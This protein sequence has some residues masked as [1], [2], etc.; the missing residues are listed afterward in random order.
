MLPIHQGTGQRLRSLRK[1]GLPGYPWSLKCLRN[2]GLPAHASSAPITEIIGLQS[3]D[4]C[5]VWKTVSRRVI[6]PIEDVSENSAMLETSSRLP[7]L[8][9]DFF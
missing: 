8:K 2:T 4:S 6:L 7:Q 3:Y 1:N 5:T 9:P